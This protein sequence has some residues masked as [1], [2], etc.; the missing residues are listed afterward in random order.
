M[1]TGAGVT[2]PLFNRIAIVGVGLLGGSLGLAARELKLCN[3]VI[4]VGRSQPSL[5]EARRVEAI[6]RGSLVPAE[7]VAQAD[8]VV[9]CTP[10]RHIIEALPELISYAQ[11]GTIF[12]D[13]GSTK[14]SIVRSG[15]AAAAQQ[16]CF[17]VGSHPMAGSEKSGVRYARPNLY[18]DSTC[19]VTK[20]PATDMNAFRKVCA[21]WQAL[22]ARIVIARPERHDRLVASVSHLPHLMAVALVRALDQFQEDKNLIKGI[23]G[24]GF[25]D[26]T[27]VACGDTRMWEDI[28]TDNHD[29]ISRAQQALEG[30]LREIME[31]CSLHEQ[32]NKL[33][34]LLQD[35]CEYREFLDQR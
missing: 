9:L 4:G 19:F 29:E 6:D 28:C 31:A 7:A 16:G 17:F 30:A 20:T 12:T 15:E 32:G 1:R 21:L 13:V 22:S 18:Q 11:P 25:R 8:L 24:N 27:R 14:A 35:A 5:D 26:T 10:V 33:R 23:I 34:D 2:D 3:E